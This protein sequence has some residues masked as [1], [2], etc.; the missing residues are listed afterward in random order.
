VFQA[1]SPSTTPLMP[2][3]QGDRPLN[4]DQPRPNGASQRPEAFLPF[5]QANVA[6]VRWVRLERGIS[7]AVQ[8]LADP[9][10]RSAVVA[11]AT[12]LTPSLPFATMPSDHNPRLGSRRIACVDDP[13]DHEPPTSH[14]MM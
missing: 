9:A 7:G 4:L 3:V 1:M 11:S 8:S 14:Q 6:M 2:G 13:V 10:T 12:A 5:H